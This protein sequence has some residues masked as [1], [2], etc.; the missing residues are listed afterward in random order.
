MS[1]S[2]VDYANQHIQLAAHAKLLLLLSRWQALA[3]HTGTHTQAH[4][5]GLP[6]TSLGLS[7]GVP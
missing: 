5:F 7:T 2:V 1:V 6:R 3:G 4:R